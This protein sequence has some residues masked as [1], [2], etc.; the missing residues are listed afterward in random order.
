MLLLFLEGFRVEAPKTK[1]LGHQAC[2]FS[3]DQNWKERVQREYF[4]WLSLCKSLSQGSLPREG[5][6]ACVEKQHAR[7]KAASVIVTFV[8]SKGT[9]LRSP[10]LSGC[11]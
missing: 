2:L 8:T 1:Q 4:Q 9:C 3:K 6:V 5:C 10:L 7:T 11:A